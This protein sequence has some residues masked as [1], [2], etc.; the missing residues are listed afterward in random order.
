MLLKGHAG[1]LRFVSRSVSH[2]RHDGEFEFPPTCSARKLARTCAEL[3]DFPASYSFCLVEHG[4]DDFG[5]P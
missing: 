5:K 4:P 3:Y 1:S 2:L